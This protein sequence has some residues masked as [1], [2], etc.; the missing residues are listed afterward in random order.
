MAEICIFKDKKTAEAVRTELSELRKLLSQRAGLM[1]VCAV[2]IDFYSLI[3][4]RRINELTDH[5]LQISERNF[6][7]EDLYGVN[8]KQHGLL[9]DDVLALS[10]LS[11]EMR[12]CLETP[13]FS[14]DKEREKLQKTIERLNV[15]A[16]EDFDRWMTEKHRTVWENHKSFLADL[17]GPHPTVEKEIR[18][19]REEYLSLREADGYDRK[20]LELLG[21]LEVLENLCRQRKNFAII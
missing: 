13:V 9:F 6:P 1:T 8:P 10:S 15:P 12:E 19:A 21:Y 20:A 5:L 14:D 4:N 2:L 16:P 3:R 17:N 7:L 18:N 11:S